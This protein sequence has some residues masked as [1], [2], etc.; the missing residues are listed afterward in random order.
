MTP[1]TRLANPIGNILAGL[2]AGCEYRRYR[3]AE[4]LPPPPGSYRAP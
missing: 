3:C 2:T 1:N 4:H